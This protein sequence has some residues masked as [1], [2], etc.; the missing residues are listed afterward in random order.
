MKSRSLFSMLALAGFFLF[1]SCVKQLDDQQVKQPAYSW[2]TWTVPLAANLESPAPAGRTETGTANFELLT[3][4]TLNYN[5]AV[6]GLGAGDA[7]T[8]AGFYAGDPITSSTNAVTNL[9]T[10]FSGNTAKGKIM[11]RPSFIDSLNKGS[12]NLYFN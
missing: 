4:G 3:D 2:K 9:P 10:T 8:G 12:N 11:L 1:P 6:N 7:L 5:I